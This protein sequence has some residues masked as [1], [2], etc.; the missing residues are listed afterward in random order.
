MRIV[1]L[2]LA[3]TL[4]LPPT[5]VLAECAWVLWTETESSRASEGRKFE[6]DLDRN[7]YE[8]RD[9]CES[10]F[11]QAREKV[12]KGFS[13]AGAQLALRL[14]VEHDFFIRLGERRVTIGRRNDPTTPDWYLVYKYACLPDTLDPRGPKGGS[15]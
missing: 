9:T 4:M 7:V 13:S 15:R 12:V 10:A 1:R 8:T 3:L 6:S 5:P 2:A 14:P 11:E